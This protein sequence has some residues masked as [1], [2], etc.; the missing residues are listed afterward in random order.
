MLPGSLLAAVLVAPSVTVATRL[1]YEGAVVRSGSSSVCYLNQINSSNIY[2][3]IRP[4]LGSAGGNVGYISLYSCHNVNEPD[5]FGMR[6][7]PLDCDNNS[8]D[9]VKTK[10]GRRLMF[11]WSRA[12]GPE[13]RE[14][15]P[16]GT[17]GVRTGETGFVLLVTT[18][19]DLTLQKVDSSGLEMDET[20]PEEAE[21]EV[22]A[23]LF[24]SHQTPRLIVLGGLDTW[25][26]YAVCHR[27]CLGRMDKDDIHIK[28]V[29]IFTGSRGARG[30]IGVLKDNG[31]DIEA[32]L[33]DERIIQ[34]P[35][36]S[37]GFGYFEKEVERSVRSRGSDLWLECDYDTELMDP[38][39]TL[40]G[41]LGQDAEHCFAVLTYLQQTEVTACRSQPTEYSV[42][43][44]L[45][46]E[47]AAQDYQE[48][49]ADYYQIE[50]FDSFYEFPDYDFGKRRRKRQAYKS[51][52][53]PFMDKFS[54]DNR[55]VGGEIIIPLLILCSDPSEAGQVPAGQQPQH[56]PAQ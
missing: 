51:I 2:S 41:G 56:Q 11:L 7:Q 14:T 35:T 46:M 21:G 37:A 42:L 20:S 22:V 44:A 49:T 5:L 55:R 45:N 16:A 47:L 32:D 28:K 36:V 6:D 53:D 9:F 18:Y 26:T 30:R 12:M 29:S 23:R 15:L 38:A 52:A 3:G 1:V 27:S 25:K 8:W 4:V 10:C 50:A 48:Y 34:S 13:Y 54:R 31:T 33:A 43:Y 17:S 40:L 39:V 24:V 19:V